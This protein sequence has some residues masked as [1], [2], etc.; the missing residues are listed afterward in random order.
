[1]FKL[2]ITTVALL[3][4]LTGCGGGGNT[5]APSDEITLERQ[6]KNYFGYLADATVKLYSVNGVEKKLLF[7]EKT[8]SGDGL[9]AIGNFDPHLRDMQREIE[10]LY[11]VSGG[12]NL[13]AD[14]DGKMDSLPTQNRKIFRTVYKNY[15]SKVAWWSTSSDGNTMAPSER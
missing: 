4:L 14:K 10:Y 11:E 15:R 3:P 5:S 7:T 8:T 2:L 9:E 12:D 13:D 1:M 6:A